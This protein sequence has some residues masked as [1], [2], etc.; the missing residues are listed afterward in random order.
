MGDNV[1]K[2]TC[3][4]RREISGRLFESLFGMEQWNVFNEGKVPEHFLIQKHWDSINADR[5]IS[6]Q[7]NFD[8]LEVKAIFDALQQDAESG[9][10]LHLIPSFN[11]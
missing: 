4:F 8:R 5:I 9:G 7:L 1:P 10:W 11:E 6:E 3:Y 2:K